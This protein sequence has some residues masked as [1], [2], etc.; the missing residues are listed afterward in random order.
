MTSA[1]AELPLETKT[2][3]AWINP[4]AGATGYY[5]V[6]YKG[7]LLQKLLKQNAKTLPVQ[8]RYAILGDALAL[9]RSGKMQDGEV[10]AVVPGLVQEG[11][12]H[13]VG[14]TAGLVSGLSDRLVS[15]ELRPNYRRLV[16]KLY[17]AKAKQLGWTPKANEDDGTRL[18]R[19]SLL[20]LVARDE[21][22]EFSDE[23]RKLTEAWLVDRKAID[24][25]LV[26][27][28]LYTAAR[29]GDRALWDKI[30]AEAKKTQD[31]KERG[32]MLSAMGAFRD[33]QIVQENLKIVLSDE[34]DPRESISLLYGAAADN[35]NRQ[36]AYDF[37]KA[38]YD[39]VVARMPREWGAG[40]AGLGGGFCD[41]QHRADVE[42]F[43]KER[44]TKS[45]GGPRSLAQT[46]ESISLCEAQLSSR[47]ASVSA[48]LKKY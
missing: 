38:N 36:T 29:T 17:S 3:P 4:N 7:D 30:H 13:L 44:V 2:C 28:V 25:D 33:P 46:L 14:M 9:V 41:A 43:Y 48:F 47:Q 24:H 27:T 1:K 20:A 12:R 21:K 26:G 22:N 40:L 32:N 37:G 45:V 16:T 6:A 11:D 15:D 39:K 42:S 18:L 35:K 10:L 5:R 23:A 34:F 31:R 19:P 8:E